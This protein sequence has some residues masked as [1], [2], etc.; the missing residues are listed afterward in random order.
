MSNN[1][2]IGT[3]IKIENQEEPPIVTIKLDNGKIVVYSVDDMRIK[4]PVT[5]D[6]RITFE[7]FTRDTN[8][9]HTNNK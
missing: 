6:N 7:P 3:I 8:D 4:K 1:E 9:N 2:V 5:N